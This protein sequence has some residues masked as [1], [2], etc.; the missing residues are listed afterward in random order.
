M[1][2]IEACF[3][4]QSYLNWEIS[5]LNVPNEWAP[6]RRA[7]LSLPLNP[8][9]FLK[10]SD[11]MTPFPWGFGWCSSLVVSQPFWENIQNQNQ[12]NKLF[13]I[14][15]SE[16]MKLSELFWIIS[17]LKSRLSITVRTPSEELYFIWHNNLAIWISGSQMK[18]S[19]SLNIF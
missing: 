15:K 3:L 10:K 8:K 14:D 4:V 12:N 18:A 19:F 9:S 17:I 6:I 16:V 13:K 11:V 7:A 5:P 1:F 2:N